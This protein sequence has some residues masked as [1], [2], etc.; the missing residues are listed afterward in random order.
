MGKR[1]T[2]DEAMRR[3]EE[4]EYAHGAALVNL[5]NRMNALEKWR[6]FVTGGLALLTVMITT[7]GVVIV[8]EY[9]ATRGG[10]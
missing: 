10:H 7:F 4:N 8:G 2:D 3:H 6:W 9:L 1:W 5:N